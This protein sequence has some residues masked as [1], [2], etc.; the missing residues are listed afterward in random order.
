MVTYQAVSHDRRPWA[1][2][3]LNTTLQPAAGE[4]HLPHGM[5]TVCFFL[6]RIGPRWQVVSERARSV[7]R[8]LAAQTFQA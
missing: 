5:R 6:Y 2:H 1:E 8:D 7:Y 3:Q 4:R